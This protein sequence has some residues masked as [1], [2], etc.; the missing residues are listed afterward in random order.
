MGKA[1]FEERSVNKMLALSAR[2][3]RFDAQNSHKKATHSGSH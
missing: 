2:G 3:L 1:A